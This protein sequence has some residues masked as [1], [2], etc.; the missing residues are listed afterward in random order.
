MVDYGK[1]SVS[2]WH[3]RTNEAWARRHQNYQN[4]MDRI[5]KRVDMREWQKEFN[6]NLKSILEEGSKGE[7]S[8]EET[9][10]RIYEGNG[11]SSTG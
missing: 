10:K 3:Q 9:L 2:T 1:L 8:L 5:Q 4:T 6:K 7:T 11:F